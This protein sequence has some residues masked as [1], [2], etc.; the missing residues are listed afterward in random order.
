MPPSE[1]FVEQYGKPGSTF[2][3]WFCSICDMSITDNT[4]PG[5][6][7]KTAT[8]CP[9]CGNPNKTEPKK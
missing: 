7:P 1:I 3:A 6:D 2:E 9:H 5:F 8:E 4:H